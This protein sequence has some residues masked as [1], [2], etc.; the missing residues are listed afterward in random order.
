MYSSH[1]LHMSITMSHILNI[2]ILI[3]DSTKGED[4]E[5]A[6]ETVGVAIG[7]PFTLNCTYN[8]TPDGFVRG[9]W[10]LTGESSNPDCMGKNTYSPVCAVSFQFANISTKDLGKVYL[11]YSEE[12]AD[13][14]LKRQTER[15][16]VLQFRGKYLKL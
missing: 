2:I 15:R 1:V 13:L 10:S 5:E 6:L 14:K 11:C 8:C 4:T 3:A 7:E 9:C 12:T 16:V